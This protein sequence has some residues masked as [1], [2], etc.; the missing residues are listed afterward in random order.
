MMFVLAVSV[1]CTVQGQKEKEAAK[2]N[3]NKAVAL[4]RQAKFDEAKTIVDGIP[5]HEKT[6]DDPKAWFVRAV[7]YA[8]MD[9]SSKY[10]G[11]AKDNSKV[12][13]EAFLKALQIAGPK[14]TTLTITDNA[15]NLGILQ[16]M[17]RFNNRFILAGDKLF[18][19]ENFKDALVQFEKS[20]DIKKDSSIYLYAG[21][22]AYNAEDTD[23]SLMYI[24]KYIESGGRTEQAYRLQVALLYEQK[25]DFEKALVAAK[26]A[27]KVFPNNPDFR[28]TELNCLLNL[29]R[30]EEAVTNVE[31]AIKADP[32]DVE[33][34]YLMGALYEE[35]QKRDEAKKYFEMA[36]KIDPKHLKSALAVAKMRDMD[37]YKKVKADM[38]KLD[39]RKDKEKLEA[40]DKQ[41]LAKMN[42]SLKFWEEISTIDPNNEDVLGNL[43]ILY[44][45]LDMKDK[46]NATISRMKANGMEV[47]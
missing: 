30:Y 46:L 37:G 12:A 18:K 27:T 5:T 32:K 15:E 35:L 17:E 44:G 47:D 6:M 28:K 8:S 34:Y 11:G 20:L 23:K 41:Y 4:A 33:S 22:T 2:P 21:Y 19:E 3:L 16:A 10:T 36:Y 42:E 9:T 24:A 26:E 31:N 7:V 25:K 13:G 14:A 38:D 1:V 40:L 43:Y 39:Y 45:Q 29:K